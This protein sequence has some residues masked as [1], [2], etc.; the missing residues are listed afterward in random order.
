MK[1]LKS[2]SEF[3][4]FIRS[5]RLTVIDFYAEWCGPCKSIAPK[6]DQMENANPDVQFGKVDVD[7]N[8]KMVS[9]LG[10]TSMPTVVFFKN[11]TEIDR[12]VGADV[13]KIRAII[14]SNG[15]AGIPG[16]KGYTLN[17]KTAENGEVVD[18]SSL[19]IAIGLSLFIGY[20]Y[21]N[22]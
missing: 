13:S 12:V 21:L 2:D 20:L 17:G 8:L 14:S 3:D 19:Y 4:T 1:L 22:K 16:G 9:T 18:N 11:G 10:I 6:L 5:N 15:K 7:D